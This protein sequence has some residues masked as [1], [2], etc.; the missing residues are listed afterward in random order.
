MFLP[1]KI[2]PVC[3]R[4]FKWRKKWAKDWEQVIYC[5]QRCRS[6]GLTKHHSAENTRSP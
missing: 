6:S 5:S 1:E 2:C 4:P 3:M